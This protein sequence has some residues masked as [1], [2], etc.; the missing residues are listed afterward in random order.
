MS[1]AGQLDD[2]LSNQGIDVPSIFFFFSLFLAIIFA[3]IFSIYEYIFQNFKKLK[4]K[5]TLSTLS[6][7]QQPIAQLYFQFINI[8]LGPL[9]L[10]SMR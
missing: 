6:P 3:K 5:G 7:N 8:I 2:R 9:D 10:W 1:Y 4:I